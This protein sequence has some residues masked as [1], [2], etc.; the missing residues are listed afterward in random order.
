MPND[1]RYEDELPDEIVYKD[2]LTGKMW[3]KDGP[4]NEIWWRD[5]GH[6]G[7]FIFSFDKTKEYNLFQ[8]YPYRLTAE[9]KE[10]F[11]KE[12]PHWKEFFADRQK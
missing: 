6:K 10:L 8:D 3:W 2:E 5:N 9:E 11:D 4:T 7:E 1:V 12:N